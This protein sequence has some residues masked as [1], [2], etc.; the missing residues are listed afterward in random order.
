RMAV[1][2]A[3]RRLEGLRDVA[4]GALMFEHAAVLQNEIRSLRWICET[5]RLAALRPVDEDFAGVAGSTVVVLSLR[6]GRLSQRHVLPL[7]AAAPSGAGTNQ[8]WVELAGANA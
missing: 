7:G 5:Q 4:A 3:V 6:G 2:S 8:E 1:R